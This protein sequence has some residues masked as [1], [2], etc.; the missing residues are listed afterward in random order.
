M[1]V[2]KLS[3]FFCYLCG[4]QRPVLPGSDLSV[5][6]VSIRDGVGRLAEQHK[7]SLHVTTVRRDT[8][9]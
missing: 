6:Q 9:Y 4:Q 2:H 8:S 7:V 3:E 1:Q 5:H